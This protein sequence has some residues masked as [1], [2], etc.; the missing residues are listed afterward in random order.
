[1]EVSAVTKEGLPALFQKVGALCFENKDKFE[2]PN[3]QGSF[4][5]NRTVNA[6]DVDPNAKKGK[7]CC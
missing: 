5:I 1:M 7:K 4:T 6:S 2:I 3:I